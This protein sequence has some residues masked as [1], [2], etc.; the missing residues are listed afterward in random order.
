M[1]TRFYNKIMV[2]LVLSL[3]PFIS[4]SIIELNESNFESE[5]NSVDLALVKFFAPW[6]GHC[7]NMA[8]D[9][10]GAAEEL[11][12]NEKVMI[13]DVDCT[14]HGEVCR[15][16]GAQGY[17]TLKAFKKGEEFEEFYHRKQADI[18]AYA[19]K[20]TGDGEA[21]ADKKEEKPVEIKSEEDPGEQEK[22]K[23]VKVTGNNFSDIV[24]DE[25]KEVFIKIY[26]PWCGHCKNMQPDWEKLA[27]KYKEDDS[28]VIAEIDA[29]ANDLPAEYKVR[30][31]PTLF[32]AGKA[33]KSAPV[34]YD[35]PRR[36]ESWVNFIKEKSDNFKDEL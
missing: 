2:K 29:T 32:W 33:N 13:A 4:C 10:K 11:A 12:G 34:K 7:K 24:L 17:P 16:V 21:A 3:L 25:S 1:G 5:I 19:R 35:G 15:K 36:V 18:V 26:A 30:G 6:C 22:G 27:E 23:I 20:H 9:W 31:Y 8:G 28:I 14:Q